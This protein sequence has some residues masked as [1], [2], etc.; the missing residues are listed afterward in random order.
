MEENLSIFI[1]VIDPQ[2]EGKKDVVVSGLKVVLTE[3]NN[4]VKSLK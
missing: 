2:M 3:T 1:L 4:K